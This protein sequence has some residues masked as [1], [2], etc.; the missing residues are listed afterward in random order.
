MLISNAWYIFYPSLVHSWKEK[1]HYG[2]DG[3]FFVVVVF[4]LGNKSEGGG[5]IP[6]KASLV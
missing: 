4:P 6:L 2:K 5:R 3:S 1:W